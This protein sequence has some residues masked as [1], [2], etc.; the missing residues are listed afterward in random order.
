MTP[1]TIAAAGIGTPKARLMYELCD[2]TDRF[3]QLDGVDWHAVLTSLAWFLRL[4][5]RPRDLL[6]PGLIVPTGMVADTIL[7]LSLAR[8]TAADES[9]P[10]PL[11][12]PTAPSQ[13][14]VMGNTQV[15]SLGFSIGTHDVVVVHPAVTHLRPELQSRV[16]A[17]KVLLLTGNPTVTDQARHLLA[18]R[19]R[20]VDF[21]VP[22]ELIL[23]GAA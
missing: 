6:R 8:V 15:P 1:A 18:S 4:D 16:Q 5:D 19:P 13:V 2:R 20:R 21:D 14:S 9:R 23:A 22:L 17:Q 11:V 3:V 10:A 7:N 12:R